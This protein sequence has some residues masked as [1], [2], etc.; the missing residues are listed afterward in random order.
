[1]GLQ[2]FCTELVFLD[3]QKI[4]QVFRG[5]KENVEEMRKNG[6]GTLRYVKIVNIVCMKLHEFELDCMKLHDAA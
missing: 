1:M 3:T 5:H 6:P 4:G 2:R